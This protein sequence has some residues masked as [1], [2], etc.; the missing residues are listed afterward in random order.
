MSIELLQFRFS[1][2]NEKARW[3]L[4]LK[5]VPHRRTSLLPG[6]HLGRVRALTGRTQ[7]PVLVADGQAIDESARIIEWLE[8]RWPEPPLFFAD[9]ARRAACEAVV[10]RFDDDIAPR[11]RRAVLGTLLH[12]P[13]YMARVF[14]DGRSRWAQRAYALVLPLAAGAVRKAN[15][16]AGPE[17]IDDGLVAIGEGLDFVAREST[18]TGFLVGDR[19][20]IADLT[21]ASVLAVCV[22]PP[23]S[24]MTRPSP[25]AEPFADLLARYARHPGAEWVRRV[26]RDHR[27]ARRDFDG[28]SPY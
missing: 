11:G 15:G 19:F 16:I 13:R 21:A 20:S 17:S 4:D 23:D 24:P 25:M 1:P 5:R 26:Y 12:T 9:P 28:P 7:T 18:A 3:A 6:P 8:A 27:G 10:R 14:G 2:Y 22:D